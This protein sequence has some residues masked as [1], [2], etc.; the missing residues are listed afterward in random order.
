MRKYLKTTII[1]TVLV[2]AA[3]LLG[4]QR[5]LKMKLG[6]GAKPTSVRI[7]V[8]TPGELTEFVTAPGEIE[9]R[10]KVDLS[11][12]VSA[13][14][15]E[16]PHREGKRVTRGNPNAEPPIAPSLLIK[17][18]SND[19]ESRLRS[20]QSSY[21][22]QEAQLAVE[23]A[24]IARQKAT[25]E[26]TAASLRQ[27]ENDFARQKQLLASRDISAATFDQIE[28][29]LQELTATYAAGQEGLKAAELNLVVL[30]HR[31]D[32]S[33]EEIEQAREALSY[34]TITSPIDGV[35]TR[36][37]AEEGEM[38]MT[39]TMNNPGT[40][41][42][43]VADL[44][45]MILVAQVDEAD[46]GNLK[47]GQKARVRVQAFWE[48]AF[49]GVVDTIALTHDLSPTRTKYY[50]TEILLDENARKLYS[51]LTADVDIETL[52]H[53]DIIKI[54]SQ[55]VVSRKIDDLPL[56]IRQNNP[57]VDM[58]KT[59]ALVV[60]RLVE[61]KAVVTPVTIGH[62]DMTHIMIKSGLSEGDK[63]VSGPYKILEGL[64][65]D[66]L[67]CD[68]TEAKEN[69]QATDKAGE[70]PNASVKKGDA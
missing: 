8:V 12:K 70:S 29:K 25:L 27:A 24:Q 30:Q 41:I 20:A 47:V 61:G 66:Q 18:D 59:E 62:G 16:L 35:I 65:H 67:I 26:G 51:G 64:K 23:K 31:L 32:A 19:L 33:R 10:T 2:T 13:R 28:C 22:A 49:T 37:N 11:A 68:E 63:V 6:G 44:S 60:Y 46:I 39:G 21:H 38:V 1:V 7:E 3:A 55:S 42:M 56:E 36:I 48:D 43:Q 50:K 9:P 52:T 53:R 4:V 34:T 17:L 15:I 14:I 5:Y 54:P 69:E 58:A 57:N 40:V 45:Q